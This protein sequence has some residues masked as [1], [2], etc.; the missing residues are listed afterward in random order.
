MII[1]VHII[2][3][4]ATWVVAFCCFSHWDRKE[5]I[6]IKLEVSFA[7][8]ADSLWVH[9]VYVIFC[10]E[11]C[12]YF[13]TDSK[14][15]MALYKILMRIIR[16]LN[17]WLKVITSLRTSKWYWKIILI[18]N[19]VLV[20]SM[21]K[22]N[23]VLFP[24]DGHSTIVQEILEQCTEPPAAVVVSVGGGGLLCGILK[25]LQD[26]GQLQPHSLSCFIFLL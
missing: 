4:P 10:C 15:S 8:P 16:K 20:S 3:C 13:C 12:C 6:I 5:R 17:I 1:F 2:H 19:T 11:N 23:S 24:R 21:G 14:V 9:K 7:I 25:G 22:W 18:T 26:H